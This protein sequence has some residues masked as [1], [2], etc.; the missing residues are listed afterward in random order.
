MKKKTI[1]VINYLFFLLIGI[2]FLWLAFRKVDLQHVWLEIKNADYFYIGL[3]IIAALISHLFRALRWNILINSMGYKTKTSTTFYAVMIG[4]LANSAVPRLGEVSRCGVLSKKDKIPFTSLFGTV[5][6]ERVFDMIVLLTIILM[7]V[8]LQYRLV[9]GFFDRN[10]VEPLFSNVE[11]NLLPIIIVS[12][13]VA[14]AIIGIIFL[15]RMYK[16]RI[17]KTPIML[18]FRKFMSG[19]LEGIRTILRIDQKGIFLFYTLVIWGMYSLMIYLPF[20]ALQDTSGLDYGDAITVMAIGSLGIVAP[21]PGG[22]GTYHFITKATLFELYGVNPDAATSF[23]T[24]TH[25]AQQIMILL[26]GALSFLLII[27]QKRR[28]ADGNAELHQVENTK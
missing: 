10:I 4:Y 7:V 22:I 23:A 14:L 5:I 20:F 28:M 1:S 18:R 12:F 21:V 3:S 13:L 25:A 17:I 9:G 16:G 26:V 6:A 2:L 11:S 24:I 15:V 27:L 8:L 19:I